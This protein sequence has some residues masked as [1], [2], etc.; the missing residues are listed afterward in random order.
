M[1]K[2][3]KDRPA[4]AMVVVDRTAANDRER[5]IGINDG[6][7]FFRFPGDG[8]ADRDVI[9]KNAEILVFDCLSKLG[10]GQQLL[11]RFAWMLRIVRR[12]HV[13]E[14]YPIRPTDSAND[15]I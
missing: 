1:D 4:L 12:R 15:F 13:R 9:E 10:R 6:L 5:G 7:A 3:V 14:A 11:D 2:A 8:N